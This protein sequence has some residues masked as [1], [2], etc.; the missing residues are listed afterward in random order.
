M[1][2]KD[3]DAYVTRG[4]KL[5]PMFSGFVALAA[6]LALIGLAWWREGR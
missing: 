6:L 4:V 5:T 3:R 1:G 2:L